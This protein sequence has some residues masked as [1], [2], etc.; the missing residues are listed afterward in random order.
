MEQSTLKVSIA[1]GD[2]FFG[3][4]VGKYAVVLDNGVVLSKMSDTEIVT[5]EPD[6][7][8]SVEVSPALQKTAKL[9]NDREE[10]I[11]TMGLQEGGEE[12]NV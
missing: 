1:G 5:Y 8:G 4:E 11:H 10:Y 9:M 2:T 7:S 3:V 12:S 6:T